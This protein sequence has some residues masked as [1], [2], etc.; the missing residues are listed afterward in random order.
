MGQTCKVFIDRIREYNPQTDQVYLEN[1][2][3]TVLTLQAEQ[4]H[5]PSVDSSGPF[6]AA[7]PSETAPPVFVKPFAL[8][9]TLLRLRLDNASI[10]AGLLLEAVNRGQMTVDAVREQFGNDAAF[11]LE[12]LHKI[13]QISQRIRVDF[14]AE[15][16]RKMIL[17]MARDIR[18]ILVRLAYCL[19][20]LRT[21]VA[22]SRK[23]PERMILEVLE[24]YAPIAHRLGVY[25][26]KSE[27]EDLSFRFSQPEVYNDL[28]NQVA[29]RCQGG[30]ETIDKV[31]AILTKRLRK[32]GV[33]GT[34]SGREK[35]LYSIWTKMAR[36]G[37][38]LDSLFDLIAYRIIVKK[39]ADCY[40]VL[41]MIHNDFRPIPGRFKDYIALPK[42]N[43]YQSL[44]TVVFG[45]FDQQIEVQIRTEKMHEVAESGVAA[46][47]VYKDSGLAQKKNTGAT[48]YAWLK[49]LLEIHRGAENPAQFL[50]NVKVD[51]FPEEIYVFTPRGKIIAMPKGAT[52]VDF[53]YAVH[54]EVGDQCQ[55]CRVN[56]RIVPLK[57]PLT[58]GDTVE[59]ITGKNRSPN[60][61][62]LQFVVTGKAKY[63]ISRWVKDQQREQSIAM[64]REML[65][66]E[67]RK[68]GPGFSLSDKSLRRAMEELALPSVEELLFRVGS[69]RLTPIQVLVKLYPELAGRLGTI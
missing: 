3:R 39:K 54:S 32:L 34:V 68:S 50:E 29:A 57:T 4:S 30:A 38:T 51:L 35:H 20:Q 45:P 60:P 6:V 10:A 65:E 69:S 18:V 66:R 59:V 58:S 47:W 46:H 53:A 42:S 13:A 56:G 11:L 61:A 27:L 64:G 5:S 28:K 21:H 1:L 22:L 48:G 31:V 8:S 12:G 67:A 44:H 16:V 14:Q 19:E 7:D 2:C 24:I 23:P 33:V 15:D 62:W 49:Q 55:G 40:L 41:G 25:W 36:R 52:P 37:A 9:D 63:R 26:I 17:G 43:G